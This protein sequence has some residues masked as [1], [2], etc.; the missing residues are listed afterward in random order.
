M[1]GFVC[2]LKERDHG[3][4]SACMKI[5]DINSLSSTGIRDEKNDSCMYA[6]CSQNMKFDELIG[7]IA[8]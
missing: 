7:I 1:Q 6:T 5:N 8:V 3:K 2:Y 4:L